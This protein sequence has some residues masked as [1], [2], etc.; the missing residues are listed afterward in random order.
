M[1][2]PNSQ[3]GEL[4][5][6][7]LKGGVINCDTCKVLF[8]ITQLSSRIIDLEDHGYVIKKRPIIVLN[9]HNRKT[10]IIEYSLDLSKLAQAKDSR[11][12][13]VA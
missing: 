10:R 9:R 2:T 3:A 11:H 1:I 12:V 13:A 8:G 4:L 7:F 5:Q 6:H